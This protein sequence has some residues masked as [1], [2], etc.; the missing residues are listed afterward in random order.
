MMHGRYAILIDK[1]IWNSA[2]KIT[3]TTDSKRL[4]RNVVVQVEITMISRGKYTFL[5]RLGLNLIERRLNV[6]EREKK[7]H[8]M[9]PRSKKSW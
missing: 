9:I 1:G 4:I 3:K 5:I 6:V 7:L 2:I 8:I